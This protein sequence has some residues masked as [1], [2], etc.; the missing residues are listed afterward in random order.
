MYLISRSE[1]HTNDVAKTT[2]VYFSTPG[3]TSED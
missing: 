2:S 1:C 3:M